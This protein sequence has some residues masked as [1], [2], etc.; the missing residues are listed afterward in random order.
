M[1]IRVKT[2]VAEP[3]RFDAAP[4]KKFLSLRLQLRPSKKKIYSDNSFGFKFIFGSVGIRVRPVLLNPE[5]LTGS[6]SPPIRI[7]PMRKGDFFHTNIFST[8]F[9]F[10]QTLLETKEILVNSGILNYLLHQ[11]NFIAYVGSGYGFFRGL[12]RIR[13]KMDRIRYHWFLEVLRIQ[14]ILFRIQL[15]KDPDHTSENPDP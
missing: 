8:F 4:G 3:N 6:G 7:R 13:S 5:V 15:C 9:A 14:T 2:S 11:G 1:K 12:I 10:Q